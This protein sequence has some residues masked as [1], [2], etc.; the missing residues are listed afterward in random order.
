LIADFLSSE[1]LLDELLDALAFAFETVE[2]G[3]VV[4]LVVIDDFFLSS[5]E[6]SDEDDVSCFF[7]LAAFVGVAGVV[8]A[9]RFR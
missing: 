6:E 8:G 3:A 9:I 5:S 4:G 7:L 2:F 1:S